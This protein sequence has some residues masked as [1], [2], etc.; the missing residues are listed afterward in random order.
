MAFTSWAAI[1]SDIK[2]AL[3]DHAAG[4]PCTRSY[5]IG[6][7][8]HTYRTPEELTKLYSLTYTLEALDTAGDPSN[9]CSY[10]SPRRFR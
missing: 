1:R 10:G 9:I 7:K 6:N 4:S 2:D 3:A 5:T 8:S